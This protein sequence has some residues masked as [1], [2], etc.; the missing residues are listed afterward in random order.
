MNFYLLFHIFKRAYESNPYEA[1]QLLK[2]CDVH[3]VAGILK[4]YLRDLPECIFTTGTRILR[5]K[6]LI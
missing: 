6:V 1:E 3:A 5:F 4:Q 2:E